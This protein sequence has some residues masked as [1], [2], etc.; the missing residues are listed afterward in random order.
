MTTL[1]D[2]SVLLDLLV[3]DPRFGGMSETAITEAKRK[4][5]LLICEAVVAEIRPALSSDSEFADFCEDIG[6]EF[7]PCSLGAAL[8]AGTIYASYLANRGSAKRVLPDFLIAAQAR[9]N[10][11]ALLARDRGY[12]RDYFQGIVLVDPSASA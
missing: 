7:E 4:G 9:S 1:I 3:S 2:S 11:Y 10:D 8:L 5:R 12:Y 6:L